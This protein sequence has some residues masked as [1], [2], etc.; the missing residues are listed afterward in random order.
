[1]YAKCHNCG[2]E[3][4]LGDRSMGFTTTTC[5]SCGTTS[6]ESHPDGRGEVKPESERIADAIGDLDG[7]GDQ[8]LDNILDTYDFY[9]EIEAASV[10]ELTDIR[11]VGDAT[12]ERIS[13]AV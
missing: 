2:D 12:A 13:A 7:V 10:D 1:M 8:T 3:H 4:P 11:L 9:V 6:Y 5:P